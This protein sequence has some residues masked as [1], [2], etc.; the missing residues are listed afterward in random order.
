M[1]DLLFVYGTLSPSLAPAHVREIMAGLKQL[2]S[3]F[4][5]GRLYDLG[6]Y[7]GAVFDVGAPTRV[8]GE[9]FELPSDSRL[10]SRLDEYEG[11][12]PADPPSS[13]FIREKRPIIVTNNVQLSCWV[14]LYNRDPGNLPLIP[15][16]NYSAW[17]ATH[18][19]SHS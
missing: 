18:H 6:D 8:Y 2:S 5:P 11:F 1:N 13:L 19:T 3:G 7:P 12:S 15:A 16:G 4:M 10:I 9:V 14:Y 17:F